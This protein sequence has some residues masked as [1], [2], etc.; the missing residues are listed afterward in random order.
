MI[1]PG[2]LLLSPPPQP[3]PQGGG[4]PIVQLENLVFNDLDEHL[5]PCGG[6]WE[7]G[8]ARWMPEIWM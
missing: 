5:P 6:G 1:D 2:I 8:E 7:G 3:S 4:C